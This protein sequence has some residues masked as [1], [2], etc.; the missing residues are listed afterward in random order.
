MSLEPDFERDLNLALGLTWAYENKSTPSSQP[1]TTSEIKQN[2]TGANI[3]QPRQSTPQNITA[4]S[5]VPTIPNTVQT[6]P[7]TNPQNVITLQT[8]TGNNNNLPSNIK[9]DKVSTNMVFSRDEYYV[10]VIT[11]VPRQASPVQ[12]T[13]MSSLPKVNV[14][15]TPPKPPEENDDQ[16]KVPKVIVKPIPNTTP[17]QPST[18]GMQP[19]KPKIKINIGKP[20]TPQQPPTVK[21]VTKVSFKIKIN[22]PTVITNKTIEVKPIQILKPLEIRESD[23]ITSLDQ[24]VEVSRPIKQ[25]DIEEVEDD[26][27]VDYKDTS[28]TYEF[29]YLEPNPKWHMFQFLL[30]RPPV[31]WRKFIRNNYVTL[32]NV[33]KDLYEKEVQFGEFFPKIPDIFKVFYLCPLRKIKVVIIGQ[34]PYHGLNANDPTKCQA[35]G[36]SF[37]V[38]RDDKP[39][40]SLKNIY[41]EL[42]NCYPNFVKPTHGDLT[43]WLKQGVFMYNA[44]L[45]VAKGQPNSH[46]PIWDEFSKFVMQTITQ[47][48][49]KVVLLLWGSFAEKMASKSGINARVMRVITTHPSPLGAKSKNARNQQFLGS[50]CFI[51]VNDLLQKT[52]QTPID[53]NVY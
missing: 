6:N 19:V 16:I 2:V 22:S 39:P 25:D 41:N 3:A 23:R 7:I 1:T 52:G 12:I 48:N 4:Q 14:N 34:D 29:N 31:G 47:T 28:K 49:E 10:P 37:G 24:L 21:P 30:N 51:E 32:E 20:S 38:A 40:P 44:T 46:V 13:P 42:Q 36:Y 15:I 53:W 27:Q 8:N 33:Q 45:T 26:A 17:V 9:L 50:K 43:S 35:Q 5:T 11:H 18:N